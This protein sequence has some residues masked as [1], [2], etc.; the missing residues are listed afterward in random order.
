MITDLSVIARHEAE[1][2]EEN[3]T[4]R[5]HLKRQQPDEL[6]AAAMRLNAEISPQIDCTQCGN[7][8]HTLMVNITKPE[9]DRISTVMNMETDAFKE[10]YVETSLAGK[11]ILN[12]MPCHFLNGKV[13]SIYEHRF[14]ECRE[15]PHLHKPG[16]HDRVFG[17]LMHY[18]R[19]PIIYNVIE[20]LKTETG[21]K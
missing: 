10:Q 2:E 7:C 14:T 15:F 3:H 13:C 16:F 8:C 17:T 18:G 12:R 20:A 4:F 19:C 11:M 21:F 5:E 1:R 6:D 9:C